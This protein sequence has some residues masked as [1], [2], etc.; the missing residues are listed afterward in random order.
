MEASVEGVNKQT[1]VRPLEVS[2]EGGA[3]ALLFVL[4]LMHS[5]LLCTG[6]RHALTICAALPQA[7]GNKVNMEGRFLRLEPTLTSSKT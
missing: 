5:W 3:A 2:M 4:F 1:E 6:A 7:Q